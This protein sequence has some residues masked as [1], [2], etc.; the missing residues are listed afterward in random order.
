MSEDS[1]NLVLQKNN[2]T[3]PHQAWQKYKKIIEILLKDFNL[4]HKNSL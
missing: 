4:T 3:K 2:Q 1:L